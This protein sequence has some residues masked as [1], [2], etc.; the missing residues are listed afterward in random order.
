MTI[1][2]VK[3]YGNDFK[4]HTGNIS[5]DN[6][7]ITNIEYTEGDSDLMLLPGFIDLHFHGCAGYDFTDGT[8]EALSTMAKFEASRGITAICPS[9]MPVDEQQLK[10]CFENAGNYESECGAL[11][12]G[13]NMEGPYLTQEKR[14]G[15]DSRYLRDP[16]LDEFKEYNRLAKGK[17]KII[18]IAPDLD[19]SLDFIKEVSKDIVVSLAHTPA[20]YETATEG[21]KA[22][23]TLVTHLFNGMSAFSHRETGLVGAALDADAFV[24]LICDGMHVSDPMLRAAYKMFGDERV[25]IISDS[26]ICTGLSDGVYPLGG[27]IVTVKDGL[28]RLEDG[29]IAGASKTVFDG[30][31]HLIECGVPIE[32][33]VRMASYNPAKV[34]GILDEMGTIEVGKMANFS[35]TDKDLN[36]KEVYIK[37]KE[38]LNQEGKNE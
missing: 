36:I 7:I 1:E 38:F 2:N 3:I 5:F 11:L 17:I 28:G 26:L 37:G 29:T 32:S 21:F 19:G 30:C 33:A 22:G 34:L 31:R 9:S 20:T 13:V 27:L 23:G 15:N 8:Y 25:V 18:D 24:E 35:L 4:F 10:K 12:V 6:G 14:G 16:D